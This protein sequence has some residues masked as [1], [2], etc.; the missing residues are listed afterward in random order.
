MT[1]EIVSFPMKNGD[2]PSFFVCLPEGIICQFWCW[3][4]SPWHGYI[5]NMSDDYFEKKQTSRGVE[6][7]W[8]GWMSWTN[9]NKNTWN[10]MKSMVFPCFS[11]FFHVFPWFSMFFHVFPCFSMFF[12]VFPCLKISMLSLVDLQLLHCASRGLGGHTPSAGSAGQSY[13]EQKLRNQATMGYNLGLCSCT[14]ETNIQ[15]MM[16]YGII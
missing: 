13:N 6:R 1:I 12:H 10:P 2:F 16:T 9:L 15:F 8:N 3:T 5:P 4:I 7:C 14:T 11:M